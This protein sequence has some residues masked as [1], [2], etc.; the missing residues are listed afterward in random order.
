[1][2]PMRHR[3]FLHPLVSVL[4]ALALAACSSKPIDLPK[5]VQITDVTTGYFDAGIVEGHK[6]KIVPTIA[7]R[8]KNI[9]S[10]S[11]ASVQVIAKFNVIG[12]PEELGSAPYVS[13]IGSEGLPPGQ[14][15]KTVVMK[16][17][18]GYTSEAPRAE[19]FTHRLFQDVKVEIFGKHAAQQFQKLGAFKINRQLLTR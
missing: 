6:N 7:F 19:M 12:D 17:N 8:L 13:A 2:T 11:I 16:T 9:S 14:T 15:G 1:M 3:H 5:A 18:L 4:A 10:E